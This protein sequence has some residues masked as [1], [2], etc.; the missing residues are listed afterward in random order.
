[1][2]SRYNYNS[3]IYTIMNNREKEDLED[4]EDI[5]DLEDIEDIE[6]LEDIEDIE[7]LEDV[8]D[9]EEKKN[10]NK[11]LNKNLNKLIQHLIK[12]HEILEEKLDRVLSILN[13]EVVENTQ[14]MS[15]HID[16]IDNIYNNVKSPLGYLC[17][18]INYLKGRD[19]TEYTIENK[20][21]HKIHIH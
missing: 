9:L 12:K 18:K 11:N 17:N 4:I 13:N 1:M 10:E 3:I 6:D 16:F 19:K 21:S 7:D 15:N 20:T 8:E 5:E 2:L 14:K